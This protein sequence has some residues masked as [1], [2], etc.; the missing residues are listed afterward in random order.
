M[1]VRNWEHNSG[2]QL[3]GRGTCKGRVRA[4]KQ[5]LRAVKAKCQFKNRHKAPHKGASFVVIIGR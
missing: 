3:K 4:A 5:T 2:K 1:N